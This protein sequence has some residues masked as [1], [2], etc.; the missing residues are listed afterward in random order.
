MEGPFKGIFTRV[1]FF[2][3]QPIFLFFTRVKFVASQDL[4]YGKTRNQSRQSAW[5]DMYVLI[6]YLILFQCMSFIKP[7][8]SFASLQQD[9]VC[10][11]DSIDYRQTLECYRSLLFHRHII[12]VLSEWEMKVFI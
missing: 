9:R 3:C 7:T 8:S 2:R 5:G 12:C 1:N 6:A 11:L 10:T 4:T